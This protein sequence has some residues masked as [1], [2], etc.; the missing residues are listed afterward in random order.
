M[1]GMSPIVRTTARLLFPFTFLFGAYVVIHGHLT[2]GGGFPG[3]VIIAA[4]F[5]MLVLA[6]GIERAQERVGFTRAE[7][8]ESIGGLTIAILGLF[9]LLAGVA[10]LQNVFPLG[11]FGRLFS[12][13][14]LPLLY[15]A[16]GV[17]V[18]A[19]I[20]LIFYAMLFGFGGEE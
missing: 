13:G 10:F 6:Y 11:E 12:G 8:L 19:G 9:G 1:A 5:V 15:L 18:T 17:K 16:V 4:S 7:V 2:P 20:L 3:G 14:N